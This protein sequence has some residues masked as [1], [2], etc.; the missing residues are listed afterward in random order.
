VHA[1]VDAQGAPRQ[2]EITPG[3]YH[4]NSS[5]EVLLDG[6]EAGAV[7]GDKA[8]DADWIIDLIESQGMLAV[9]P[10]TAMRKEQRDI[11]KELYKER[12]VVERFFNRIKHYR[13]LATR[14]EKTV[15]SYLAMLLLAC[16]KGWLL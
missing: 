15:E 5:A 12:N 3:N 14:Y 7:I 8:Y 1:R 13:G 2:L 11:D 6:I 9:I 10:S 16:I 4:D